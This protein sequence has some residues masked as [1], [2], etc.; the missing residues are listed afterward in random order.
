MDQTPLNFSSTTTEQ[1]NILSSNN[2]MKFP[3]LPKI[4]IFSYCRNFYIQNVCHYL[5]ECFPKDIYI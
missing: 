2:V 1:P 3:T 5:Q 4:Q